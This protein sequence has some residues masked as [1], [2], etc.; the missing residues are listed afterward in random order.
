M[1]RCP[2]CHIQIAMGRIFCPTHWFQVPQALRDRIWELYRV[3]RGSPAHRQA[4]LQA[5]RGFREAP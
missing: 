5:I 4:V 2:I 3:A 1:N